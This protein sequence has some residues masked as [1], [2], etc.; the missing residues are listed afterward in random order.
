MK[1]IFPVIVVGVILGLAPSQAHGQSITEFEEYTV[2]KGDTCTSIAEKFFGDKRRYDYIHAYN[3]LSKDNYACV[4]GKQLKIAK[5]PPVPDALVGQKAGDVRAR[6]PAQP[7]WNEAQAGMDLYSAWRL[8]TMD[9]ARAEIAFQDTSNLLMAPNTLVIIYGESRDKS[10]VVPAKT[11]LETGRL[12]SKL[13]ELAGVTIES[14]SSI[15]E[16]GTGQAQM[17]V[18]EGGLTRVENHLGKATTVVGKAG[19]KVAVKPGMGTRIKPNE[20]PEPPR[21]LPPTPVWKQEGGLALGVGGAGA[22]IT[23]AWEPVKEATSYYVEL[24]RDPRGV[25]VVESVFV[26]AEKTRLEIKGVPAG[27]FYAVISSVDADKFESIPTAVRHI[28]STVVA[29][30]ERA[31]A[32]GEDGLAH[33]VLGT[34]V[35]APKGVLCRTSGDTDFGEK[36][37]FRKAGQADLE[38]KLGDQFGKTP[39]LVNAPT[40]ARA[41]ERRLSTL[42]KRVVQ[43]AFAPAAP[44]GVTFTASNAELDTAVPTPEGYAI[45]LKALS[46]EPVHVTAQYGDLPLATFAFEVDPVAASQHRDVDVFRLHMMAGYA[47]YDGI[48]ALDVGIAG[49]SLHVQGSVIPTKYLGLAASL[50]AGQFDQSVLDWRALAL[51]GLFESDARPFAGVGPGG[52]V[53]EDHQLVMHAELGVMPNISEDFGW[54]FE[55]GAMFTA[56]GGDF[57][58]VPQARVGLWWSF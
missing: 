28:R 36:A 51:V 43:L 8:N 24:A 13:D 58:A 1:P 48:P 12:R 17:T 19:G 26:P 33:V 21:P 9:Q 53:V 29:S 40:A 39:V 7:N 52:I 38:C 10:Q 37:I 44:E 5:I 31:V 16:F 6:G 32:L 23:L 27:T 47:Y 14:P 2:Q 45:R 30:S 34:E 46:T 56:N 41:D 57:G 55:A 3:D 22:T 11:V 25:D 15:A 20:K 54:T 35:R 50:G 49:A 42:S 18:E 4:P